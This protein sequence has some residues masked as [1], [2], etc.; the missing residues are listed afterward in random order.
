[1]YIMLST[2]TCTTTLTYLCTLHIFITYSSHIHHIF[3]TYSSHIHRTFIFITYSSHIHHIFITYSSHNHHI[4]I[5]YLSHIHVFTYKFTNS[6]L[7]IITTTICNIICFNFI[8][9]ITC[10]NMKISST[11]W[12]TS[13]IFL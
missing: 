8:V 6:Y 13:L 4:I 12:T 1:M 5:T 2:L 9:V 10:N 3:I 7:F 11:V